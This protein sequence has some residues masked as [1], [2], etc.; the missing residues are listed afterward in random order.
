MVRY[1]A[2]TFKLF[3]LRHGAHDAALQQ[4]APG[5]GGQIPVLSEGRVIATITVIFI[6]WKVEDGCDPLLGLIIVEIFTF[7]PV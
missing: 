2:L 5:G 6:I 1:C 4:E 3:L 7:Y